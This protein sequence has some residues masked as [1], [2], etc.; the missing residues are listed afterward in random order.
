M[1]GRGVDLDPVCV[2]ACVRACVRVCVYTA[3]QYNHLTSY[4]AT[5]IPTLY[6][7]L[8]YIKLDCIN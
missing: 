6:G 8:P 3:S 4:P 5:S 2:C 7:L 1:S